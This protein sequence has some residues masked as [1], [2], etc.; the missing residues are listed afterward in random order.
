ML[1]IVT[2]SV[3]FPFFAFPFQ[4]YSL[5]INTEFALSVSFS[6]RFFLHEIKGHCDC[7]LTCNIKVPNN[8]NVSSPPKFWITYEN[9]LSYKLISNY[10]VLLLLQLSNCENNESTWTDLKPFYQVTV[11]YEFINYQIWKQNVRLCLLIILMFAWALKNL[12]PGKQRDV[13]KWVQTSSYKI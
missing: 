3:K 12:Y 9:L 8:F 2:L 1:L 6:D 5:K 13:S 10:K 4:E 7:L 11:F